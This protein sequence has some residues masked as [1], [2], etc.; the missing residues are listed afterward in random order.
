VSLEEWKKEGLN[1][2]RGGPTRKANVS[3]IRCGMRCE[4]ENHPKIGEFGPLP[5]G[6]TSKV[7]WLCACDAEKMGRWAAGPQI[8]TVTQATG[9]QHQCLSACGPLL[10]KHFGAGGLASPG[11]QAQ[12]GVSP[13]GV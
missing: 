4:R 9:S 8:I 12:P 10:T 3:M 6:V 5:A 11:T 13:K 7:G 2:L 1:P